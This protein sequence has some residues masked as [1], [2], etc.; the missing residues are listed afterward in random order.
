MMISL[1]PSY[2]RT[3]V[4]VF[5]VLF[6][7]MST[8]IANAESS[9]IPY[10]EKTSLDVDEIKSNK[11]NDEMLDIDQLATMLGAWQRPRFGKRLSSLAKK[12]DLYNRLDYL[13]DLELAN[14]LGRMQRPRVINTWHFR[15]NG[16]E[17]NRRN[18]TERT[19]NFRS[20]RLV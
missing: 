20:V 11:R 12:Y 6:L 16:T 4:K 7:I 5:G 17:C 10:S 13:N 19:R 14:T 8:M 2:Y 1:T 15:R 3:M 9:F 18:V